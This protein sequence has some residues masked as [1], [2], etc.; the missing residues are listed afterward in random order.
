MQRG[1]G[2]NPSLERRCHDEPSA[3]QRYEEEM[4]KKGKNIYGMCHY[5]K[6]TARSMGSVGSNISTGHLRDQRK[7][8]G[9]NL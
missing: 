6:K 3:Q 2:I 4:A 1:G 7:Q 8:R 5:S 9:D